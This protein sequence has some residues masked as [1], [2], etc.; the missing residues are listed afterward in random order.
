MGLLKGD[1]SSLDCS[2]WGLGSPL[3]K[4]EDYEAQRPPGPDLA[5]IHSL[6]ELSL[7]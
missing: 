1:A 2:S 6:F 4:G 3:Q 5:N 7:Y